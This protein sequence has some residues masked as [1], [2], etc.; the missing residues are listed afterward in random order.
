M[1]HVGS[2]NTCKQRVAQLSVKM[3]P[4]GCRAFSAGSPLLYDVFCHASLAT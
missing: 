2:K 1:R 3:T 4:S